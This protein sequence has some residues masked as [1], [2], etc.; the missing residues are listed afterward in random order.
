[1][2]DFK[3]RGLLPLAEMYVGLQGIL[4]GEQFFS[5]G[6]ICSSARFYVW[7]VGSSD[8]I[9]SDFAPPG[10]PGTLVMSLSLSGTVSCWLSRKERAGPER[11]IVACR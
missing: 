11:Y 9:M 8:H 2:M 4:L 3:G 7:D 1:M 5:G 10:L 6:A